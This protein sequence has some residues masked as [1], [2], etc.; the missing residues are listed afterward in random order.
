MSIL[1]SINSNKCCSCFVLVINGISLTVSVQCHFGVIQCTGLKMVCNSKVA[2]P[3][4]KR[5]EI[6]ESG[7]SCTKYMGVSLTS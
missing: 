5:S 7:F 3:R 6:W 4:V 1:V 2:G